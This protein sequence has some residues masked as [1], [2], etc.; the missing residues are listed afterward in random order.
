MDARY[1][2]PAGAFS[3][4]LPQGWTSYAAEAAGLRQVTVL[5]PGRDA[6][7]LA[8]LTRP[9]GGRSAG[10]VLE[11]FVALLYRDALVL[12]SIEDE[13]SVQIAG[14]EVHAVETIA[15]VYAINSIAL[16]YPRG[17]IWV[18]RV[19]HPDAAF[20]L[21]TVRGL[22]AP[23]DQAATLAAIAQGF[24]PAVGTAAA[25]T[26]PGIAPESLP[27]ISPGPMPGTTPSGLS[28]AEPGVLFDG[29]SMVGLLPVAFNGAEFA[30]AAQLTPQGLQIAFAEKMGW[31]K[32][33]IVATEQPVTL[34]GP[35][36]AVRLRAE[37][38]GARTS[39]LTL[40]LMPAG[41]ASEDPSD[42][43]SL[44]LQFLD[45]GEGLGKVILQV[46]ARAE[47]YEARFLWP[48]GPDT[49]DVLIR[50]DRVIEIR[51]AAGDGLAEL[52]YGVDLGD[53]P[54]VV[55]ALLPVES[56]NRP[57]I[58]TLRRLLLDLTEFT[59]PPDLDA[60]VDAPTGEIAL[61]D[62]RGLGR[63]WAGNARREGQYD[64]FAR[65]EGGALRLGW[66][67]EDGG[68]YAGI[69][70]PEVVVWLDGLR[71]AAET[72]IAVTLDPADSGDFEIGLAGRFTLPGNLGDN[73]SYVLR[74]TRQPDG[75]FQALSALRAHP[76][77][78]VL[79]EG[80]A[81]L[82]E[83][84]DLVLHAGQLHVEAP[85]LSPDPLALP[86][87]SEGTGLRIAVH[88]LADA[89]GR[90]AL[91]LRGITRAQTP[92]PA[93]TAAA[94]AAKPQVPPLPQRALFT[95]PMGPG[96]LGHSE[97]KAEF[98]ALAMAGPTG[99]TLSRGD[100]VPDGNRIAITGPDPA[101][102]LDHRLEVTPYQITLALDPDDTLGM[103]FYLSDAPDR[104][105]DSARAVLTARV[106]PDGPQ[107]GGL[108]LRLH[109]GHFSYD[110]W[111][112]V[113][114]A[115]WWQGQWGGHLGLRFGPETIT[116]MVDDRPAMVGR[117]AVSRIGATLFPALVPGGLAKTD[118]GRVTLRAITA[119]WVAPAGMTA[120]TRE[121]LLDTAEF[122][123]EAFL[124]FLNADVR[125]DK[126]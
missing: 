39:A 51:N 37:I 56:K 9:E 93:A 20:L 108:E 68:S 17:R 53:E 92:A 15:K 40:A 97:G 31:A 63:L 57:A 94:N 70:S 124:D 103:R 1:T 8:V 71:G 12:K 113:L 109:T 126:P 84:V 101:L 50:P 36:Q 102:V 60:W 76:K 73:D 58:L 46:A 22:E 120:S 64:R 116:V 14:Q 19:P 27:E 86:F 54:L 25:A 77:E 44:Q 110:H 78:G 83:R 32:A 85:G 62:G 42:K 115:D 95:P 119:A 61:F 29:G 79:T 104:F 28:S 7:V 72:R 45:L 112:R 90:G 43:H 48:K 21:V 65:F 75:T 6:L 24:L 11:D 38:D 4:P 118:P 105:E 117:T 106:L 74:F 111:R 18:Y 16:P 80:L 96:W 91:A 89:E 69:V 88:A 5:S 52:G 26:A 55:Q 30:S 66:T 125:K 100:P 34:P 67:P 35:D 87:V 82:P 99:L 98:A 13:A 114:P 121:A 122:N 41:Q 3:L 23:A 107:A 59:P 10:Q 2:D 81:T 123:P 47:T 49:F 33:G